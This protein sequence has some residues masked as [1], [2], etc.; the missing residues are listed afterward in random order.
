M[1]LFKYIQT[2]LL[3]RGR[4][5]VEIEDSIG[6]LIHLKKNC[7]FMSFVSLLL[8]ECDPG[9]HGKNCN[10]TCGHCFQKEK[11][12]INNGTCR[13]GCDAGFTGVLC[14]SCIYYCIEYDVVISNT[15]LF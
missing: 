13:N 2:I 6:R 12:F 15:L 3:N 5:T 4:I 14:K 1:K 8:L 7:L 9:Y 11:C 10:Y